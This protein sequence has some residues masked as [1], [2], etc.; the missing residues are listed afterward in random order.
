M[1]SEDK[2]MLLELRQMLEL[3]IAISQAEEAIQ[4]A[5]LSPL[6]KALAVDLLTKVAA[7]LMTVYTKIIE[8][9]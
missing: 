6:A 4:A 9:W 5:E 7:R 1:C 2:A 3:I 8:Q